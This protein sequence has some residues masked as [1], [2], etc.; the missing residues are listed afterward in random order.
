MAVYWHKDKLIK[1]KNK[2]NHFKKHSVTTVRVRDETL[3]KI[4]SN[5]IIYNQK[6]SLQNVAN[7]L[8]KYL[9]KFNDIFNFLSIHPTSK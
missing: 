8:I 4:N 3:P 6:E 9:S 2:N 7:N 1:D 5:H